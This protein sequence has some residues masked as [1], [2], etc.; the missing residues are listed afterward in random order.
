MT[1]VAHW[2]ALDRKHIWH[3]YTQEATALPP[4]PMASGRGAWLYGMDGQEYL[5][6]IASWWVSI[7]GHA[8]PAIARAI[9]TQA[10]QLEQVIFAGF[11]HEPAIRLV[12]ALVARLPKGL[13]RFFFSDDGS[14][15]VEVAMK[16][17]RQYWLN[18]GQERSRFLV[19]EGG[20]HGDTVGAMSA[21]QSS[22]Y[23]NA[24]RPLLFNV[25]TLVY[26]A[27]WE[28][29]EAVEAKENAALLALDLYLE[30]HGT[31]CAAVL[32]EPL[33]QGAGGMRMCRP[34]FVAALAARLKAAGVLLIFDEVMTGFGRTGT[35]FACEKAGVEPDLLC[36]SKGLTGGFLP[37]SLTVCR[38]EIHAAFLGETFARALAHGHS[39]TANA[40]GCAAALASLELFTTENTLQRIAAIEAIHRERLAALHH[41]VRCPRVM[42]AIAAF[43]LKIPDTGYASTTTP[44]LIRFFLERGLIIRPLGAVIYLMP[45]Y[46]IS[47]TDLH[48]GWDG[49][50]EA[51]ECF[52]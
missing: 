8:H 38:E 22:G 10:G 46:C 42:G 47:P 13:T 19:F 51:V 40:L 4:I 23:F 28:G 33:V 36:L 31:E 49:I 15:A 21:G 43:E 25:D 32:I 9:A 14:T 6:L 34:G 16:M 18:L 39:F 20:Y 12:E 5:D 3:P 11:T 30:R 17:A 37:M 35:L 26:P 44:R 7:H 24:F 1:D 41:R 45:P 48:R 29:D 50:E 52:V 2:I 27:T